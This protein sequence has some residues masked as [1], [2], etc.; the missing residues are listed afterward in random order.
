MTC[1][2][3]LPYEIATTISTLE[4]NEINSLFISAGSIMHL[5]YHQTLPNVM[6]YTHTV[7]N[8]TLVRDHHVI[9]NVTMQYC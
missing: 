5:H 8:Y 4:H 7:A 2:K 3:Y 6:Q 1:H 9:N